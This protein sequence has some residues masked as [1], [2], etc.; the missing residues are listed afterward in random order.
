VSIASRIEVKRRF[1]SKRYKPALT[2]S[3]RNSSGFST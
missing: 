1:E 2:V 3:D